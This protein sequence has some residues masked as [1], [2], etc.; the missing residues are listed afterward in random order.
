MNTKHQVNRALHC[1]RLEAPAVVVDDVSKIVLG[2]I[3][4]LEEALIWCSGSADF[5]DGGQAREGWLKLCA[6][7][8]E[9]ITAG[10]PN[11]PAKETP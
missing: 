8:L 6:P 11:G 10:P 1:L 4:K 2:H 3:A 5:G 7:L 9:N